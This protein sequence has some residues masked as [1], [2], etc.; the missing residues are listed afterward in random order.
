MKITSMLNKAAI[1][2]EQFVCFL[3]VQSRPSTDDRDWP[4]WGDEYI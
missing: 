3:T 4:L 2:N 1:H